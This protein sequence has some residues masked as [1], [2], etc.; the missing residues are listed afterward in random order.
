MCGY[1]ARLH[2]EVQIQGLKVHPALS[3][4]NNMIQ[5]E[6][7]QHSTEMRNMHANVKKR[8]PVT[9]QWQI[10]QCHRCVAFVE[11]CLKISKV[12]NII[13]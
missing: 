13:A 10:G 3:R 2:A 9:P 7:K 12:S 4:K 8:P 11:C 5:W 6:W 1:I